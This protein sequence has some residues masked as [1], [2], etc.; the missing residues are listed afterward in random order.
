MV[1][2]PGPKTSRFHD[3]CYEDGMNG[4][5]LGIVLGIKNGIMNGIMNGILNGIILG[6]NNSYWD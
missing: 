5:L 2:V 4:T 1:P 3:S 6:I